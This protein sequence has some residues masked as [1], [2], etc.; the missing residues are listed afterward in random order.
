V[1][2]PVVA[3]KVSGKPRRPRTAKSECPRLEHVG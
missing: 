1:A 2:T 3:G